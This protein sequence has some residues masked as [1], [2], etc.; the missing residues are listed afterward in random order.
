MEYLQD[1]L[2]WTLKKVTTPSQNSY[3]VRIKLEVSFHQKFF[4]AFPFQNIKTAA[5]L[6]DY[7][8]IFIF[9]ESLAHNL[10]IFESRKYFSTL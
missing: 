10:N 6:T 2:H 3:L 8:I 7:N 9:N 4:L 5:K 1:S